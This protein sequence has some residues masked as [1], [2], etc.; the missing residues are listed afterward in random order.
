MS[1]IIERINDS[2]YYVKYQLGRGMPIKKIHNFS[3]SIYL[4]LKIVMLR[5]NMFETYNRLK[6]NLDYVYV[7]N[8]IFYWEDYDITNHE[9][10]KITIE[11][12]NICNEI[13]MNR[14][15]NILRD[16]K[17][18]DIDGSFKSKENNSY[19]FEI[20]DSIIKS[21]IDFIDKQNLECCVCYEKC[22]N[23]IEYCKHII[24]LKCLT[25]I[26]N[27]PICRTM[28]ICNCINCSE[29]YNSDDN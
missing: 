22:C 11:L 19:N 29:I 7:H 8:N 1:I 21:D 2:R 15:M 20:I 6:I 5:E 27:C 10:N 24:C 23:F 12:I 25:R 26:K 3:V 4:E 9:S 14:V 17:Y 28:K 18:D 13:T 16:L